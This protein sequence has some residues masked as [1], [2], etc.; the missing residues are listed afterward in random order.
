MI[1]LAIDSSAITA[2]V[3]ILNDGKLIS[4]CYVNNSLTHSR[5]LLPMV[6]NALSQADINLNSIEAIAVNTG[7]LDDQILL[8]AGANI[9]FPTMTALSDAWKNLSEG[10]VPD[11]N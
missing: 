7:P 6:K 11:R 10:Q 5:T 9:L 2:G 1:L 4:E 3:A 8:N